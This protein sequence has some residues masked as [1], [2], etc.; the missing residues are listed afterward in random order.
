MKNNDNEIR[1]ETNPVEDALWW[2]TLL[3]LGLKILAL[4][5]FGVYCIVKIAMK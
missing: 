3:K 1:L 4:V 5:L 2:W